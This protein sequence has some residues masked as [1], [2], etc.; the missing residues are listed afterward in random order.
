MTIDPIT[1]SCE[2]MRKPSILNFEKD[3]FEGA[4]FDV[5]HYFIRFVDVNV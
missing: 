3:S 4:K 2:V 5:S 1:M